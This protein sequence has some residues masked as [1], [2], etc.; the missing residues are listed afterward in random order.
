MIWT[1]PAPWCACGRAC[2][3]GRFRRS[4]AKRQPRICY[5]GGAG[6]ALARVPRKLATEPTESSLH[7]TERNPVGCEPSAKAEI[8]PAAEEAWDCA[9]RLPRLPARQQHSA[10]SIACSHEAAP[11]TARPL[12]CAGDHGLHA[13]G[14]G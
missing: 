5:L 3:T 12:R 1:S 6:K 11:G 13:F 4:V 8:S 10:R 14:R 2:G 9:M 7:Y